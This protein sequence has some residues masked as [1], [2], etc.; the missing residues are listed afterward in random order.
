MKN[1][2]E[3]VKNINFSEEINKSDKQDKKRYVILTVWELILISWVV[4]I[5][6]FLRPKNIELSSANE[7]LLGTLPSLFGAAAFVAILF[8]FH[9]ILKMYYG[10][11]SLYNSIIF[12]VLFTFIGFTVW[13]TVRTILYPFDI[14]D[15]IMTLIGCMM[16]GVLII[17]LF[18][19]DL[20]TKKDRPF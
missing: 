5:Q 12:S 16:S 1:L 14:H 4:Y 6:Y 8:A 7:F 18:L 3:E 10:K 19:D 2:I 11:Y 20:K 9:R 13:E 17:I 15:V